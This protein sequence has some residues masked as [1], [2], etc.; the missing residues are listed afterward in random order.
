MLCHVVVWRLC[1]PDLP[2]LGDLLSTDL[3]NN[4]G[5]NIPTFSAHK[6]LSIIE[7][8]PRVFCRAEVSPIFITQVIQR[9][10]RGG[11]IDEI[12]VFIRLE[13]DRKKSRLMGI[14]SV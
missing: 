4:Y 11:G 14:R 2:Y 9:V 10:A 6:S 12:I 3:Y 1:N 7:I 13:R 8:S 5:F